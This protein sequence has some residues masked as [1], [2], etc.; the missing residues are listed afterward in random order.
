MIM[1]SCIEQ[2]IIVF[3]SADGCRPFSSLVADNG[4]AFPDNM[5]FNVKDDLAVLPFSSG[6]TG[7]PKGVMLTHYNLVSNVCQIG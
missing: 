5:D 1:Y 4:G 2:E 6:T 3:G 7:L